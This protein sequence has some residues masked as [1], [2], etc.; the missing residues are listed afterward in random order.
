MRE[1]II[2]W[3]VTDNRQTENAKVEAS[4]NLRFAESGTKKRHTRTDM[5]RSAKR[6]KYTIQTDRQKGQM[7]KENKRTNWPQNRPLT[8]RRVNISVRGGER[9]GRSY[10]EVEEV[11]GR[12]DYLNENLS[13]FYR[14][15]LRRED[16]KEKGA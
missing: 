9:I 10:E 1:H 11:V 5:K 8:G 13:G 3:L 4:L 7:I 16:T 6:N 15:L 2:S 14:T 12:R